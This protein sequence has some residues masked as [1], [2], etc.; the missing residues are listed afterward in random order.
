MSYA[1]DHNRLKTTINFIQDSIQADDTIDVLN[2]DFTSG[3]Y[4]ILPGE[5]HYH[6]SGHEFSSNYCYP[7]DASSGIVHDVLDV[8]D[9]HIEENIHFRYHIFMPKGQKTS[10]KVVLMLHGFNEK[11]WSKYYTWA[12]RIVEETGKAVILFPIALHMNRAPM[13]WSETRG[14][15]TASEQRKK[16]Y[17]YLLNSSL[18]NVAI[19]TR[20]HAKPQRYVWS[21]LQTYYDIIQ[22]LEQIKAGK[23]SA[24]EATTGID[25]FVYSIGAFLAEILMMADHNNYFSKSKLI[26]FCGGPVFNRISPVSKFILDS[27]ADVRL[28]SF[29]VEHLDSHIEKDDRLKHYLG[30]QHIEGLY[31]RSML[32]YSA[33]SELRENRFREIAERM[34]ALALEGDT[35]IYPYEVLNTLQGKY[36]NIPVAIDILQ[37]PYPFIHEVPF[38]STAKIANEVSE[39]FDNVFSRICKQLQ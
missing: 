5:D 32:N 34:Y 23:H 19:S 17:S 14:M 29:L 11:S 13:A 38:P 8:H 15:F 18:S 26:M 37:L 31:F 1:A 27:E 20:L 7:F 21:G 16:S 9:S 22:L 39:Q 4:N 3:S 28:Y 25:I 36:R 6:C 33:F 30:E 2:F 35:V 12:K 24:I 10:N